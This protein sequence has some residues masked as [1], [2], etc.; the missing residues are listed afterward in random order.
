MV[1][2][3]VEDL[4]VR[5]STSRFALVRYFVG[6]AQSALVLAEGARPLWDNFGV[7]FRRLS[8]AK[9]VNKFLVRVNYLVSSA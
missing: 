7:Q 4:E 9:L 5:S 8:N 3:V 1:F 6:S 2:V